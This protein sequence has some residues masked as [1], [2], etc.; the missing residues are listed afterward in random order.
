MNVRDRSPVPP[1]QHAGAALFDWISLIGV[2]LRPTLAD[3]LRVDGRDAHCSRVNAPGLTSTNHSN[4][5]IAQILEKAKEFF[6]SAY[7]VPGGV[8]GW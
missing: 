8:A 5:N 1:G 4:N 6:L 7:F 2:V 3:L